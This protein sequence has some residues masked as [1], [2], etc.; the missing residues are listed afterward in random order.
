MLGSALN[1]NDHS[2]ALEAF[3]SITT[4]STQTVLPEWNGAKPQIRPDLLPKEI[5][6]ELSRYVEAVKF[7]RWGVMAR[8][9]KLRGIA[10]N[11][12]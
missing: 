4:P 8:F 5:H 11:T 6:N 7:Q 2:V 3:R 9:P 10:K 1:R 12:G